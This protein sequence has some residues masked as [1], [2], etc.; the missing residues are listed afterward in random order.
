MATKISLDAAYG[1]K[2]GGEKPFVPAPRTQVQ[3]VAPLPGSDKV[4]T[5]P[6]DPQIL[7]GLRGI[8]KEFEIP[9]EDLL[10]FADQESGYNP[11][12]YNSEFG[13]AGM[14]Q[15]IPDSAKARNLDP[16]DYLAAA[17]AT[18]ADYKAQ[19]SKGREWAIKHHFA[20]PNERGHGPKTRQYLA[21]VSKRASD[22]R[23]LLDGKY[24]QD[25]QNPASV[26][27]V[28]G[29]TEG[30]PKPTTPRKVSLD[31]V[32]GMAKPEGRKSSGPAPKV[33]YPQDVST[34]IIEAAK[35]GLPALERGWKHVKNRFLTDLGQIP[36]DSPDYTPT[37]G[38]PDPFAEVRDTGR[39]IQRQ[40][41]AAIEATKPKKIGFLANLENPAKLLTEDSLPANFLESLGNAPESERNQFFEARKVMQQ[42]NIVAH[43]ER[44]PAVAVESAQQA[45]AAREAKQSPEVK[46]MWN[47]LKI[48][49]KEDPGGIGAQ[50]AN[51]LIADPY[52]VLAPEG[53]LPKVYK[54][55]QRGASIARRVGAV[56]TK[57]ADAATT[58]AAIN[59]GIEAASAQSEGRELTGSD[60]AFAAATGG[61]PAGLLAPLFGRGAGA[62]EKL[63]TGKVTEETLQDAL[64]AGAAE[65][66]TIDEILK[67]LSKYGPSEVPRNIK[68]EIE[69][70]TGVMFESDADLKAYLDIRRKEWK[71]LFADRDLNGQFQRA[72]A[73][74]RISRAETIAQQAE[75]RRAAQAA[76]A[77]RQQ[78]VA[79]SMAEAAGER[80]KRF[81]DE[82]EQALRARDE[83]M[84]RQTEDQAY[85][86]DRLREITGR[87]DQQEIIDAAFEG[88][89]QVR[90]AM[91]RAT[92]RDSKLATPKWQR[93]EVDPKLLARLGA[94]GLFA[95]TAFAL[96][97]EEQ[98]IKAAFAGGL[99]GLLLPG[100]GNVLRKM[101]QSGAVTLEGDIISL[102]AKEGKLK[103]GKSAAEQKA[104]DAEL[105]NLASKGDQRAFKELYTT[106]FPQVQR[107][108]RNFVRESGPRLGIDAEDVAQEA[109]V[110]AFQSLNSFNGESQF[111][112]WLTAIARNKALDFIRQAKSDQAGGEFQFGST[113][114]SDVRTAHGETYARDVFDEGIDHPDTI[115]EQPASPEQIRE[116]EDTEKVLIK[117]IEGL[118]EEQRVPFVLN[119]IEQLTAQEIADKL[120]RPLGTVLYQINTA[121]GIIDRTIQ[122][123]YNAT[124]QTAEVPVQRGR[125]RPRKQA[126]EVDPMLLKAAGIATGGAIAA[127][128]WSGMT[129][130]EDMEDAEKIQRRI[131]A[132]VAGAGSGLLLFGAKRAGLRG[133]VK[134]ADDILGASSTRILNRSPRIHKAI[135]S[136]ERKI[137]DRTHQHLTNVDPFLEKLKSLPAEG[138]GILSRA[139][140]TGRGAVIDR[141]LKA[142]DDPE[143]IAEYKK[144]R[145]TLD[146]IGDKLVNLRRFDLKNIEYFPRVVK[147]KEG[148]F[149]AI[150]KEEAANIK[151]ILENANADSMRKHGRP[152]NPMEESAIINKTLFVDKRGAQLDFTKNR[153]IEEITPELQQFYASPEEALHSYIRDAVQDIESADFFGSHAR[154]VKKGKYEHLDVDGSVKAM[155]AEE[156]KSGK[157][158]DDDAKVISDLLRARFKEG[159]RGESDIIRN[160]KNIGNMGLLGNFLS[161]GTQLADVGMQ[162][163]VQGLMPTL[164][165][166][167]RQLTGKKILG[168]KDLGLVDHISEEFAGQLQ[169]TRWLH[170]VFKYSLFKGVDEF[171]KN[172]GINAALAKG[173]SLANSENGVTRLSKK[174]G[175]AFGDDFDTLVSDLKKGKVS[176]LT[177]DYAFLELSRTQPISRIEMPQ[178]Y[179]KHPNLR[180]Y[181]WLKSFMMKQIDLV[182]RDA[183]NEV[184]KGDPASVAKGLKNLAEIGV[185]MGL[186]GMTTDKVKKWILGED[187]DFAWTDIPENMLKTFGFS[188][189]KRDEIF[190]VSKA[191]AERRREEGDERARSSKAEPV[192]ALAGIIAPPFQVFDQLLRGDPKA[193]RYIV[194]IV[195]PHVAKW[196]KDS[197]EEEE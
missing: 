3:D 47:Q 6:K 70:A 90:D 123:S 164:E 191:E 55:A 96:A 44:F 171:G 21:D 35:G 178:A 105:I 180:S 56:T 124:R 184:K 2:S 116:R 137:L 173:R 115:H 141:I 71:K 65:S 150:G 26:A 146:S 18:A 167:G 149:N 113:D 183:F 57:I 132:T 24:G 160:I 84:Q 81:A 196:L 37:K 51:A 106:Y 155:M 74:E 103:I 16:Y 156:I 25:P 95:G 100:G 153:G 64:N 109:F 108:V 118:T 157:L 67:N 30:G 1:L 186:A 69:Q 98:K 52:M 152:L 76:E 45:I 94:G 39:R 11:K 77:A 9:E 58:G 79:R 78:D 188:Q 28:G 163:Y 42:E 121:Q 13:A 33:G 43:P 128:V 87:L 166:V 91:L 187:V 140:M 36:A 22:I 15:Y 195:G 60:L 194:P 145:T 97:P 14:F 197:Q 125:G 111:S 117:A 32:Y 99:A 93:G 41:T 122:R 17:R 119:R 126:G 8:A 192:S 130:D 49:F 50:F 154:N 189:F 29:S 165:A 101:R 107:Y 34:T 68:H 158:S 12:A 85:V 159:M 7:E 148:L 4:G 170:K 53:I 193:L 147:D 120:N 176:E 151:Q 92:A 23:A 127:N 182:R 185:V 27:G 75:E 136:T 129:D 102:L 66:N 72:K 59:L 133:L 139:L 174:Y 5:L 19:V 48:A 161:A 175:E 181:L 135:V 61:I 62:L 20:G 162:V 31:E 54:T 10:A 177:K 179:L 168:V 110:K 73:E 138:R 112:T 172:T 46:E 38:A 63:K 169:T 131:V 88:A 89:P 80:S 144:V 83:N 143:L 134:H 82:Y 190:G 104:A 142:F 114:L 86:E 40:E